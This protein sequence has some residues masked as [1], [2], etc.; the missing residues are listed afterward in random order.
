VG[1]SKYAI[2]IKSSAAAELESIRTFDRRRI[3]DAMNSDL[4][5]EPSAETG[6][7]KMLKGITVAGFTFDPPLWELKVGEFR[8]Y[9]DVDQNGVRVIVRAVRHKGTRTTEEVLR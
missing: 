6:R 7:R 2:V 3:I 4:Q 5:F 8:V 1:T 9:Y